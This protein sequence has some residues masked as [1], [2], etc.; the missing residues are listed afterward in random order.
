[1]AD[2]FLIRGIFPEMK[3]RQ[4]MRICAP[5]NNIFLTVHKNAFS[6]WVLTTGTP[7]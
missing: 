6:F 4:T 1:M 2:T 7:F 3:I 5:T